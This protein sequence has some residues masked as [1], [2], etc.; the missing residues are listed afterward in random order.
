LDCRAV[1]GTPDA[2]VHNRATRATD[3][4]LHCEKT[5]REGFPSLGIAL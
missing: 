1:S 2:R 4:S 5:A 3:P